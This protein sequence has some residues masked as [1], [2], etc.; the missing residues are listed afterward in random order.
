M[1]QKWTAKKPDAK[2]PKPPAPKSKLVTRPQ[3][4]TEMGVIPGT[5]SR[6]ERDGMPVAKRAPRGQSSMFD[7]EAVKAWRE[8]T[9]TASDREA[10]FSLSLSRAKE[11][12]KRTEKLDLEIAKQR[13]ELVHRDQVI[14]EGHA[15]GRAVAARIRSLPRRAEHAG[16][17]ERKQVA[18]LEELCREILVEISSSKTFG[19]KDTAP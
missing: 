19:S 11:S 2:P 1:A 12:E 13:G 9:G 4:A 14:R 8:K 5:I 17:I 15:F 18:G 10:T 6:W 16:V 7:L 3:L